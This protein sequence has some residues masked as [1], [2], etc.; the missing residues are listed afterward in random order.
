MNH[1]TLSKLLVTGSFCLA[2][3]MLLTLVGCGGSGGNAVAS[4][5]V[6]TTTTAELQTLGAAL[7]FDT[8]LSEPAGQSC[9]SCHLPAAGF[10][11]PDHSH[12]T[13]KGA[14]AGRFGNRNAPTASY[15]AF[16]P[17]FRLSTAPNGTLNFVGG[18]FWDGRAST[19]EVQ[20]QG[21]FL[22]VLEMN[23][24]SKAAVID[25]LKHAS[26]ANDFKAVFGAN[27]LDNVDTAYAQIAQAIAAF[28]RTS[29]F[30]PFTS[31]F[32]AVQK[33]QATFTAAE[34]NGFNLFNG[35][36]QCAACHHTP[37]GP[38][39]FSDFVYHNVGVPANPNNPFLS[40]DT[41]LNPAGSAF[42]DLGLGGVLNAASENG[43]FRTQSLRNIAVTGPY[44]HNGVLATLT[45]VVNFYN[46]RDTDHIVPEVNQNVDNGGR[47][48][49]LG[50]SNTE[51][52]DMIAFLGTLTDGYLH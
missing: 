18:Q 31:K 32:D 49:E 15:V 16:I 9:A 30:S 50:L 21:P 51:I 37:A 29:T 1:E 2:V 42:I 17:G 7:Y 5:S 4:T 52:Q 38:E 19:L 13:S 11:D 23:N 14:V 25:K 8:N 47:I 39:V 3:F 44:M 40:L 20:A 26:Y 48:G 41:S 45:D 10:V 43:K 6:T 46:R 27:A 34:Q 12:P 28:E 22:N 35:K 33:G 24:A 36:G